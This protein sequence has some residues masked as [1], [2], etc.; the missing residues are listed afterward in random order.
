[1]A[2]RWRSVAE[3]LAEREADEAA[4]SARVQARTEGQATAAAIDRLPSAPVVDED[5]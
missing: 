1:M 4:Q 5:P 3:W 2:R